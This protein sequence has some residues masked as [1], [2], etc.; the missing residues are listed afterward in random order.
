MTKP[1]VE[2]RIKEHAFLGN[3]LLRALIFCL[4]SPYIR[5]G[6]SVSLIKTWKYYISIAVSF[7]PIIYFMF[8][9]ILSKCYI[10]FQP[11]GSYDLGSLYTSFYCIYILPA[12]WETTTNTRK[13]K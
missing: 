7:F 10:K 11:P 8:K 3:S 9:A 2:T 4:Y 13:S 1:T 12:V 6:G 5:D